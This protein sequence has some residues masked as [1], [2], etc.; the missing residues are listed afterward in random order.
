MIG[1][2]PFWAPLDV[3]VP[4]VFILD[5]VPWLTVANLLRVTLVLSS[6]ENT[7][8]TVPHMFAR[9]RTNY[10]VEFN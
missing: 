3:K 9:V 1:T 6:G 8:R 7:N 2:Q 5:N 4:F 10:E